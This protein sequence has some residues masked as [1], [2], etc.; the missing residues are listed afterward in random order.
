MQYKMAKQIW[1]RWGKFCD[2]WKPQSSQYNPEMK[3]RR[4]KKNGDEVKRNTLLQVDDK[5]L[6]NI[7]DESENSSKS[8]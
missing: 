5:K 8:T 4:E 1:K 3:W 7:Y 6:T 2:K